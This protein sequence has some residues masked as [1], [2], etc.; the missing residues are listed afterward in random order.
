VFFQPFGCPHA[1]H[2]FFHPLHAP[3]SGTCSFTHYMTTKPAR[4]LSPFMWPLYLTRLFHPL[5]GP[6]AWHMFFHPLRGSCAW[7][8]YF[9]RYVALT[10]RACV[11]SPIRCSHTWH[12]YFHPL[13][14]LRPGTCSSPS[15]L[16]PRGSLRVLHCALISTLLKKIFKTKQ[17]KIP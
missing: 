9:T 8:V 7:H 1:G 13:C 4:V 16:P 12:V 2:V 6:H 10:P 15:T 14:A 17:R 11:L 5:R 3:R